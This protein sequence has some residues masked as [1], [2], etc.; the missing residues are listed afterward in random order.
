MTAQKKTW[1]DHVNV[2]NIFYGAIITLAAQS[3]YTN[4]TGFAVDAYRTVKNTPVQD[5]CIKRMEKKLDFVV[6]VLEN[7]IV[8]RNF[9]MHHVRRDSTFQA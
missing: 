8:K 2:K 5:S 6:E 9:F 4:V 1:K 3:I 7:G